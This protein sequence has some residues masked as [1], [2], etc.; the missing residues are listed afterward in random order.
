M[1]EEKPFT[2]A[3]RLGDISCYAGMEMIFFFDFGD[4]WEFLVQVEETDA[5]TSVESE[6]VLLKSHGKA[7]QQYPDYDD[8]W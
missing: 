7:P 1:L 4:S 2:D 5:D 3:T 8:E 6:P